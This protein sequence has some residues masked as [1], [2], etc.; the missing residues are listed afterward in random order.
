LPPNSPE[1]CV[2]LI[3][4]DLA[5]LDAVAPLAD[6]FEVRIDLIGADWRQVAERLN[7]P[8]IACARLAA[9]GGRWK[10]KESERIQVLRDAVALGASIIDVE[11]ATPNLA[12][13]IKETRGRAQILI[14]YHNVKETP[15]LES[16]RRIVEQKLEA[17]ADIC[18]VVTTAR[19]FADNLTVLKLITEFSSKKKIVS[20]AMGEK[21]QLSR[22][23]CPL[24]GG[25]FT[26]ASLGEGKES[27]EGQITA[28]H[29][30][31]IYRILGVKS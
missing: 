9:E 6:I 11:L 5:A 23:L 20:F 27:A 18:K 7:K 17:G 31:E 26:Y 12:N 8:W 4:N 28:E 21:G 1:I 15:P 10:G 30:R 19:S 14:S 13:F 3:S 24:A 29:L 16:L 22:I 25:S 2:A